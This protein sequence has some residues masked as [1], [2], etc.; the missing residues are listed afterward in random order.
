MTASLN[1]L[2]YQ[3]K[4]IIDYLDTLIYLRRFMLLTIIL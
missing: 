1:I 4:R 2:V 3:S